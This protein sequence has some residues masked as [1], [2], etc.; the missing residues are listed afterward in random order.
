MSCV[1]S[2]KNPITGSLVVAD[3]VLQGDPD[4]AVGPEVCRTAELKEEILNLCRETLARHK[5][6]TAIRFVADLDIA[7]SGKMERHEA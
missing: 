6:P 5:V 1:R 3:V 2:R 4:P 7:E